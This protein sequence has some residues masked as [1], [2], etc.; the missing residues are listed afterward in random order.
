MHPLLG[1]FFRLDS[2]GG[3][4][5]LGNVCDAGLLAVPQRAKGAAGIPAT[6]PFE[7]LNHPFGPTVG[8]ERTLAELNA[9]G[10]PAYLIE[11]GVVAQ[12]MHYYVGHISRHVRPGSRAVMALANANDGEGQIFRPKGQGV[13]GGGFNNLAMDG[14]ELNVWPCEGSTRQEFKW[15]VRKEFEV[16]GH[17]W[18]GQPT[19]SCVLNAP[20]PSFEGVLLGSCNLTLGEAG[21]FDIVPMPNSTAFEN[22]TIILS[23]PPN[24]S[25][26]EESC[27]IIKE[28]ANNGGALGPR[29]G[30]QIDFGDCSSPSVSLVS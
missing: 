5:H 26:R 30:A 13:A 24:K 1:H 6:L 18:L 2:I 11:K 19:T 16:F 4:N 7:H 27:L 23:N 17:N 29:G 14:I 3:P 21:T 15:N 9:L 28:L 22:V 25:P 10:M 8:N 12:P 20:D